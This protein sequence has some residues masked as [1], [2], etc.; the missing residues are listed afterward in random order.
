MS[1]LPSL[2]SLPHAPSLI[3]NLPHSTEALSCPSLCQPSQSLLLWVVRCW[4]G[5]VA[6]QPYPA[7][8]EVPRPWS[9]VPEAPSS[10]L[11]MQS[12]RAGVGGARRMC[13][14]PWACVSAEEHLWEQEC[15]H[16]PSRGS[17]ADVSLSTCSLLDGRPGELAHSCRLP[18]RAT[19][20]LPQ[21]AGLARALWA[22][23]V[24]A[25]VRRP[26]LSTSVLST[27]LTCLSPFS[28]GWP[29]P[30]QES[31]AAPLAWPAHGV[32]LIDQES[33]WGESPSCSLIACFS[34]RASITPH[35]HSVPTWVQSGL[36]V[37]CVWSFFGP[38][39]ILT[40]PAPTGARFLSQPWT[41][42]IRLPSWVVLSRGN[43]Q[44][45]GGRS[46][47]GGSALPCSLDGVSGCVGQ[48][49]DPLGRCP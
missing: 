7:R 32:S 11:G 13:E 21:R 2:C 35:P 29:R 45:A 4:E 43:P 36:S 6:A 27:P 42:N 23:V 10:S 47:V 33:V 49:P 19:P 12:F 22:G 20:C 17:T 18:V 9:S 38:H 48:D 46:A 25:S 34:S 37:C 28:P 30:L 14:S 16:P 39:W 15:E 5:W 44:S 41:S 24:I 8:P 31:L 40:L 26:S 1:L 3:P